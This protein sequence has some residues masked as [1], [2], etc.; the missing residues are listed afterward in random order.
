MISWKC[1]HLFMIFKKKLTKIN[2]GRSFGSFKKSTRSSVPVVTI[3]SVCQADST[4]LVPLFLLKELWFND[5]YSI[6]GNHAHHGKDGEQFRCQA[7][8]K[9]GKCQGLS[10]GA[11]HLLNILL[12]GSSLSYLKQEVSL[13]RYMAVVYLIF[14]IWYTKK[15]VK[16][17][18][19]STF[20]YR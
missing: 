15:K 7:F 20:V 13:K 5:E 3:I 1:I 14:I 9:L 2:F 4:E 6:T 18:S 16:Q 8:L 19:H 12:K 10:F 17:I 11:D